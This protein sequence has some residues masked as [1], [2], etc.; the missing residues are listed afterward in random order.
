MGSFPSSDTISRLKSE[1]PKA[2]AKDRASRST[3]LDHPEATAC[4]YPLC[5]ADWQAQMSLL[6]LCPQHLARYM[7]Q[8]EAQSIFY[9]LTK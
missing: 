8:G 9:L 6:L 3:A 2:I 1:P 4:S 7:T 5:G